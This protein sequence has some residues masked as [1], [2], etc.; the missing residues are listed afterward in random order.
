MEGCL[1]RANVAT[2]A[3][4]CAVG[5]FKIPFG[6]DQTSGEANLDFVYRSLG[7]DYLSPGRDVGGEVHGRFF[8]RGLNYW[9]GWFQHDGENSR[10]TKMVGGDETFAGFAVDR[11]QPL[12]KYGPTFLKRRDRRLVAPRATSPTSRF[13]P[14]G[15]RGRTVCHSTRFSSRMFVN[16]PRRTVWDAISTGSRVRSALEPNTCSSATPATIRALATRTSR[17]S[18]AKAWYVLGTWVVTGE[19]KERPLE[20]KK[21]VFRRWARRGGGWPRGSTSCGFDS[22]PGIRIRRS[23]IRAPRRFFRMA[24]GR[25]RSA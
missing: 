13:L 8:K 20:P 19:K 12:R 17:T 4:R 25:R 18:E 6:L 5:K 23:E 22:K 1:R 24:T 3:C 10:S 16:G 21:G 2:T 7:G 11:V 15:L 9:A 14:N